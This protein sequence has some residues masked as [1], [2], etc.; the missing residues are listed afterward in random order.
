MSVHVNCLTSHVSASEC[1]LKF[2]WLEF[3][4]YARLRVPIHKRVSCLDVMY[5]TLCVEA[6]TA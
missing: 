1:Y 3:V 2:A 5:V 6:L 4:C